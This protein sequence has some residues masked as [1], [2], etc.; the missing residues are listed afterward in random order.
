MKP[1][2]ITYVLPVYW[3]AIGGCEL[4]THEL[5][6]RLCERH[7]I[8]VITLINNQKDKERG[9]DLWVSCVL[10]APNTPDTYN[11]HKAVVTRLML[12]GYE[13]S[14]LLRLQGPKIPVALRRYAMG[15]FIRFY[16]RRLMEMIKGCDLVHAIHGDVSWLG[17][18]AMLAARERNIPFVYTPLSHLYQKGKAITRTYQNMNVFPISELKMSARGTVNNIWLKTCYEADA[19]LTMTRFERDFFVGNDINKNAYAIGVGPIV[20][21]HPSENFKERHGITDK[22]VVLFLGRL[23]RDKGVEETLKAARIVWERVPETYFFFIGPMEWGC[24]DVFKKYRDGRVVVI[25]PAD[26]HEKSAALKACDILCVPSV[27]ESL[28][29]VY[30]EAWFYGKPVIGTNIPPFQEISGNGQ[31]GVIVEPSPEE[32]AKGILLLL[33]NPLIRGRMGEWGRQRVLEEYNWG[34]ISNKVEEIYYNLCG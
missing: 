26:M 9:G 28:G 16:K 27:T 18:A 33:E 25:G 8:N 10:S 30:L 20:L 17:Y 11:D 2:K 22:Q 6:M 4:H 5:V 19:L 24:N 32:I 31:G 12:K 1:L 7:V 3:P 29:G 15:I 13:K 21:E 34:N 23:N 14:I